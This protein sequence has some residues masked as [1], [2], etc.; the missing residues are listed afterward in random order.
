MFQSR[1]RWSIW[2]QFQSARVFFTPWRCVQNGTLF[3]RRVCPGIYAKTSQRV[4]CEVT[5]CRF[6]TQTRL[7]QKCKTF[8][9]RYVTY[10]WHAIE[11]QGQRVSLRIHI[12]C[13]HMSNLNSN[14]L[15]T[16]NEGCLMFSFTCN[17]RWSFVLSTRSSLTIWLETGVHFLAF[18]TLRV[19]LWLRSSFIFWRCL[20]TWFFMFVGC[21]GVHCSCAGPRWR[22]RSA[23]WVE[24]QMAKRF[25]LW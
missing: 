8:P 18:S 15:W 12:A 6:D 16:S 24:D 4:R 23:S 11:R 25:I 19:W 22:K 5:A 7:S 20:W 9:G 3:A 2:C 13:I 1:G 10:L 21:E 14:N 17:F